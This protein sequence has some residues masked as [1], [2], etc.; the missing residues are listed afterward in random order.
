MTILN[1]GDGTVVTVQPGVAPQWE[2]PWCGS[3]GTP[4]LTAD[5]L[6][7]A[8]F[9]TRDPRRDPRVVER[10]PLMCDEC[11]GVGAAADFSLDPVVLDAACS[12]GMLI[13]GV[14]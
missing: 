3:H 7:R 2:C 8:E 9:H 13:G 4:I 6:H 10:N 11:N 5:N 12:D 1:F 14:A